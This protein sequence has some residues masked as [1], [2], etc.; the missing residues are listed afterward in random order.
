MTLVGNRIP[1]DFFLT[2]GSG[3]SEITVHAGSYHLALRAAGIEMANIITYSSILP[4]RSRQVPRPEHIEHGCVMETIMS[5]TSCDRGD[6]ATAGLI[7]GWLHDENGEKYGGL[8]CEYNGSLPK[9]EAEPHLRDMIDEL[10]QNG[11]EHLDLS[12][13]QI[14]V[15]S[16][17]PHKR[18]GTALV[19]LCFVNYEIP[20][21]A[22]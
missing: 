21:A 1:R 13:D 7:F 22:A 10:H 2:S 6:M 17:T 9:E 4:R 14:K 15:E 11:Y 16:I 8:V 19:A 20:G 12:V 5:W 18:Y 3:E